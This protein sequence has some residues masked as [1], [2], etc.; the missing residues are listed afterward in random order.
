MLCNLRREDGRARWGN[1]RLAIAVRL[2]IREAF[3]QRVCMPIMMHE[4]IGSAEWA[5]S[6]LLK[7]FGGCNLTSTYQRRWIA[8]MFKRHA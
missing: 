5:R 8:A 3:A 6:S 1:V 7:D 4:K 2:K